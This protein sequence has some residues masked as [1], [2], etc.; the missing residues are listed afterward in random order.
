[1][2]VCCVCRGSEGVATRV[3]YLGWQVGPG[4]VHGSGYTAE[5]VETSA[6][7]HKSLVNDV[8]LSGHGV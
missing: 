5:V 4:F 7:C 3:L 2:Y 1:M 6:R 8:F